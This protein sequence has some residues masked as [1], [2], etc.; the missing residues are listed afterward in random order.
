MNEFF[1]AK[2]R[3]CNKKLYFNSNYLL[4]RAQLVTAFDEVVDVKVLDSEDVENLELLERPELGITFTKLHCWKLVQFSKCVFLDAD[5]LVSSLP[6]FRRVLRFPGF[7]SGVLPVK[8][9]DF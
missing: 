8:N 1:G 7:G 3:L 2:L 4:F 5:T 9:T 6:L